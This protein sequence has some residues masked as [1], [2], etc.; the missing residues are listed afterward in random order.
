M[1]QGCES[2]MKHSKK[3]DEGLRGASTTVEALSIRCNFLQKNESNLVECSGREIH[4][5]R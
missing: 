5:T 3:S 2:S 4:Y 1:K